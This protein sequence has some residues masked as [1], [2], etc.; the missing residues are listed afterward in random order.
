MF[1]SGLAGIKELGVLGLLG[2]EDGTRDSSRG[3]NE[4]WV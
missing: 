3:A 2:M 4:V 1:P